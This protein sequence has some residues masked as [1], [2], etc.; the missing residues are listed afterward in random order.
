MLGS[1]RMN[2]RAAGL[3]ELGGGEAGRR[4]SSRLEA[5]ALRR[6]RD[7]LR[8][9]PPALFRFGAFEPVP[10]NLTLRDMFNFL[11]KADLVLVEPDARGR[12]GVLAPG[13]GGL[14]ASV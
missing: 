14:E 9:Q 6:L 7:R 13:Q 3:D 12:G 2:L 11:Y 5:A 4:S 10:G 1:H 8:R